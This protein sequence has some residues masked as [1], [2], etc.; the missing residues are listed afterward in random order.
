MSEA[1]H[2]QPQAA[3]AE[4]AKITLADHTLDHVMEK[5]AALT[6][7]TLRLS[8]EVSVTIVDRGKPATVASTGSL[9]TDLDE[10]QYDRGYGPCLDCIAGGEPLLVK[11]MDTERRWADW[12]K[13]ASSAGA[14]SSLSIPVPIQREVSAALNIYS[15]DPDAFDRDTVEL[16]TTFAAYAGVALANMHLYQAQG[17]VAEHL[18]QAMQSRATIEQAKGILMGQRRC[19]PQEAFDILV[20][21]SQESNRKLRDVAEALVAQAMS[22][23]G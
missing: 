19:G 12:A 9:A 2:I 10:R 8:G 15:T 23:E 3:F 7:D 6:K 1:P 4:L 18:Q 16:A 22:D 20:W 5:V 17:Q 21:L 14:G 13:S 11:N